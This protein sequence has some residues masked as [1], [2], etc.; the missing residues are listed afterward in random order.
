MTNR[1]H[2]ILN[3]MEECIVDLKIELC[4]NDFDTA[5]A[6]KRKDELKETRARGGKAR[7][8]KLSPERRREI[9]RNA[10]N[11]RWA[12]RDKHLDVLGFRNR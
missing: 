11:A 6:R 3:Q 9:A 7:A 1:I 10:V 5:L 12:K 4:D 8:E 2:K